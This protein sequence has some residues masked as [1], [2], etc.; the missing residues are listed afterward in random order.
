MLLFDCLFVQVPTSGLIPS[1]CEFPKVL[2]KFHLTIRL[3]HFLYLVQSTQYT[4][5]RVIRIYYRQDLHWYRKL[6][7]I[8]VILVSLIA[9]LSVLIFISLDPVLSSWIM[10][11]I[12]GCV[13]LLIPL[14]VLNTHPGIAKKKKTLVAT[15]SAWN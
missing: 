1:L 6:L 11:L 12:Y 14:I 8:F 13:T 5:V 7:V 15:V 4:V 10:S 9:I 2:K 3:L